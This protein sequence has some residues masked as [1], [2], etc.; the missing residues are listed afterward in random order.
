MKECSLGLYVSHLLKITINCF[1]GLNVQM[2]Y[3]TEGG[4]FSIDIVL[5]PPVQR[6]NLPL[7]EGTSVV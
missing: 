2:E 3:V 4:L 5:L 7:P 6:R 1:A